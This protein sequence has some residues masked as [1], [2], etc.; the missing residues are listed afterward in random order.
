MPAVIASCIL[1]MIFGFGLCAYLIA[2][3]LKVEE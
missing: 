1:G 2:L 3:Q